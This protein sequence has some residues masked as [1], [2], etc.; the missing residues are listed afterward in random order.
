MYK[1]SAHSGHYHA[2]IHDYQKNNNN[3]NN[4][5]HHDDDEKGS[6]NQSE[7]PENNIDNNV[8]D[9]WYDFND[10]N[11]RINP[12]NPNNP[13]KPN[14]PDNPNKPN[15]PNKPSIKYMILFVLSS[16]YMCIL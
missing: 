9:H 5:N 13:D 4:N 11:V 6:E 10:S 8:L 1:G 16:L 7:G 15:K 2:F 14:N 12:I 3:N